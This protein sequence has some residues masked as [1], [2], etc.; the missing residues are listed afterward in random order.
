MWLIAFTGLAFT[1][2]CFMFIK[3]IQE[4]ESEMSKAE[5]TCICLSP[6]IGVFLTRLILFLLVKPTHTSIGRTLAALF[7]F[8]STENFESLFNEKC[9]EE[10]TQ[11][12]AMSDMQEETN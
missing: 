11:S 3:L 2:I 7:G 10:E 12:I 1:L 5:L 4:S 6:V 8:W 9:V